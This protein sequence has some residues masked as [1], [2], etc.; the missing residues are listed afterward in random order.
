MAMMAI[1][2]STSTNVAPRQPCP[3]DALPSFGAIC[4]ADEKSPAD[5]GMPTEHPETAVARILHPR[6]PW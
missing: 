2:T 1:T 6:P 5:R 4:F 3:N